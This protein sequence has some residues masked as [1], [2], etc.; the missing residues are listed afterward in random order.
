MLG[1][2]QKRVCR[3]VV[4]TLAASLALLAHRRYLDGLSLCYRF[5]FD[6][7]PTELA[8][9]VP[10]PQSR[11][12]SKR[13]SDKLHDFSVTISRFH[14][15][16]YVNCF[17][18]RRARLWNYLSAESFLLTYDLSGIKSQINSHLL[19]LGSF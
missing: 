8:E 13:Y 17:F 12:R 19:S 1:K 7:C 2:L 15:D 9:L 4:P 18:K 3:T 5:Y 6:R 11:W 14:K 10:L 16:V